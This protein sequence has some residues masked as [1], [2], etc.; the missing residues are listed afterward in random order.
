[1][2]DTLVYDSNFILSTARDAV[3]AFAGDSKEAAEKYTGEAI[4]F[5]NRSEPGELILRQTI[6]HL[7]EVKND[8]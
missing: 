4:R 8:D 5:L 6:A 1:M 7:K 3:R 2:T